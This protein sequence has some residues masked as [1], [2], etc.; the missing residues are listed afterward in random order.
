MASNYN[1]VPRPGVVAIEDGMARA[2]VRA[3][4]IEDVLGLDLG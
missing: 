3:E 1:M 2:I 4:T